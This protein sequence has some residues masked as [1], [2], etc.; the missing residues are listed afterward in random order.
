MKEYV[1]SLLK[2]AFTADKFG[3]TPFYRGTEEYIAPEIIIP[4]NNIDSELYQS[5]GFIP[6]RWSELSVRTFF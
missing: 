4:D 3:E 1:N 6:E 5:N 2:K